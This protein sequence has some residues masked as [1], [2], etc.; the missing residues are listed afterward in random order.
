MFPLVLLLWEAAEKMWLE[1]NTM[2]HGTTDEE[3]SRAKRSRMNARLKIAYAK[4]NKISLAQQIQ[5]FAI[6]LERRRQYKINA[7]ERWLESVEA[8]RRNKSRHDEK[9]KNRDRNILLFFKCSISK[10]RHRKEKIHSTTA[11]PYIRPSQKQATLTVEKKTR[12]A[13]LGEIQDNKTSLRAEPTYVGNLTA[14]SKIKAKKTSEKIKER[15]IT[16]HEAIKI[17]HRKTRNSRIWD[18]FKAKTA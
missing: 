11:S 5:L 10:K 8:A 14:E 16:L 7:N 12:I 18:H 2:E 15:A 9:Q 4:K 13:N 3:R 17:T 6:P 1:R